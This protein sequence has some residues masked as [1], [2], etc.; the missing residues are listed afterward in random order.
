MKE[1]LPEVAEKQARHEENLKLLHNF[2]WRG[3]FYRWGIGMKPKRDNESVI[4]KYLER[5][6]NY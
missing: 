5:N 6:E 4:G 3:T 2:R 1:R